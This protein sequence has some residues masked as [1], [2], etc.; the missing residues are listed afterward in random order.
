[1][2]GVY[3]DQAQNEVFSLYLDGPG[4]DLRNALPISALDLHMM[5]SPD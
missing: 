2:L 3:H 5:A 1:M 4:G